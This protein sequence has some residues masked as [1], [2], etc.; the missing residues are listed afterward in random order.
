MD[1]FDCGAVLFESGEGEEALRV[2]CVVTNE[3]ELRVMQQSDGPLTEWSFD[4]TP[5]GIE[6]IVDADGVR[7]LCS[8]FHVEAP[9]YLPAV[10]R[11]EYTGHDCLRRIRVLCERLGLD[12]HMQEVP[13][14]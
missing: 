13:Q 2:E 4:E 14:A 6:L 5:H 3:G 7:A 10:L 8:Y 11:M 1:V 9:S 12:E